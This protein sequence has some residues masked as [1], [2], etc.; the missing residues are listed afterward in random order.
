MNAKDPQE[1][2]SKMHRVLRGLPNRKAP[3]GLEA[4]VLAELSRRAALPWWR[5]SFAHWPSSI[6]VTFFALS[7]LAA[8]VLVSG[9]FTLGQSPGAHA[10]AS[11]ISSGYGWFVL[12]R[13]IG[14]AAG[15]RAR[16]LLASIPAYWLYGATALVAVSLASVAALGAATFRA[17]STAR[18]S[19]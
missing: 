2:E 14:A 19:S 3:S 15:D 6:R 13:E 5:K 7:G 17:L 16:M 18:Q 9:L 10:L 8:A 12:A 1:L 11:G 4:R